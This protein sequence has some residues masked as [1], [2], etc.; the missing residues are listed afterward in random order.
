MLRVSLSREVRDTLRA[1]DETKSQI[2]ALPK[3]SK[4]VLDQMKKDFVVETVYY[5]NKLA[6]SE[7]S[8]EDTKRALGQRA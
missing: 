1:I 2:A 4:E 8:E 7:L 3:P 5:A 6:G